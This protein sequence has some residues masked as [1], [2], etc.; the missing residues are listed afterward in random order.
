[1]TMTKREIEHAAIKADLA[2]GTTFDNNHKYKDLDVLVCVDYAEPGSSELI[3]AINLDFAYF[4]NLADL[5]DRTWTLEQ[6]LDCETETGYTAEF[7]KWVNALVERRLPDHLAYM[8]LS[9]DEQH[10][11][12]EAHLNPK[13]IDDGDYNYEYIE[14]NDDTGPMQHHFL[15]YHA[16]KKIKIVAEV[17][18][19]KKDEVMLLIYDSLARTEPLVNGDTWPI[20]RLLKNPGSGCYELTDAFN[21]WVRELVDSEVA[22]A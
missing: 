9:E 7:V 11:V 18:E 16:G 20:S 14:S 21:C 19:A 3:I 6:M 15:A 17:V 4:F 1:M 12:M 22:T 2:A 13:D 10:A 5:D 8:A